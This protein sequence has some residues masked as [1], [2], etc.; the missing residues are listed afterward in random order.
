MLEEG[1]AEEA[2]FP[3]RLGMEKRQQAGRGF[4]F[5]I[6]IEEFEPFGDFPDG[7]RIEPGC[8]K[9]FAEGVGIRA[10]G[11][12][13]AQGGLEWRGATAH[14]GVENGFAGLREIFDEVCGEGG[15]EAGAVGDFVERMRIALAFAPEG[16]GF[17]RS[18]HLWR[19]YRGKGCFSRRGERS[20]FD[21]KTGKPA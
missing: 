21:E 7:R 3:E 6:P 16:T 19:Q 12:A 9:H 2:D 17:D 10:C 18:I 8:G 20:G 5:L 11:G 1:G 14:E 13:P 4:D 15:L